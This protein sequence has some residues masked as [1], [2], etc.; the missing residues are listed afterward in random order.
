MVLTARKKPLHMPKAPKPTT[1][2]PVSITPT[3]FSQSETLPQASQFLQN[4]PIDVMKHRPPYNVLS[5]TLANNPQSYSKNTSQDY[6]HLLVK[7]NKK[8]CKLIQNII[9]FL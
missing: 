5:V 2:S 3:N 9:D 8:D 4:K 1:S 6:S 7:P